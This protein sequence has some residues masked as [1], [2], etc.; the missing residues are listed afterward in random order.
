MKYLKRGV[1]RAGTGCAG[2]V[3]SAKIGRK[4]RARRKGAREGTACALPA[5]HLHFSFSFSFSFVT[6]KTFSLFIFFF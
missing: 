3:L 1:A 2:F 4:I 6:A 5:F